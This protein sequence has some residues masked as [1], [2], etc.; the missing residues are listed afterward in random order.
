[1]IV[2]SLPKR[3]EARLHKLAM[4]TGRTP[5]LLARKAIMRYLEEKECLL[6]AEVEAKSTGAEEKQT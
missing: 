5:A 3:I 1:M 6:L 2:I 4:R